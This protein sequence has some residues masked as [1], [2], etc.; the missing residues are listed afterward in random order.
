MAN[1]E[2][3]IKLLFAATAMILAI[4]VAVTIKQDKGNGE[5]PTE[6]LQET[7][8]EYMEG[9]SEQEETEISYESITVPDE[10]TTM[11][12]APTDF[13]DWEIHKASNDEPDTGETIPD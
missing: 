5:K 6:T 1:N 13:S 8:M 3:V 4:V 2:K 7:S 10:E 11:E 9:T 12:V